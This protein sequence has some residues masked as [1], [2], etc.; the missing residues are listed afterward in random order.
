M[1]DDEADL[2]DILS[3][4]LAVEGYTVETAE[5]GLVALDKIARTSYDVVVSDIQMPGLDGIGLYAALEARRSHLTNRFVLVTGSSLTPEA[6][7]FVRRT[8]VPMLTKPFD[9]G[10]VRR[11]V[12]EILARP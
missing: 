10:D 8:Q 4:S 5:N 12:R 6:Q 11:V 9:V 2:L 7:Q 1:V 3:G